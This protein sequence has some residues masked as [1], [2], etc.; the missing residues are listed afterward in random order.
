MEADADN[1]LP[2]AKRIS[3]CGLSRIKFDEGG[4]RVMRTSIEGRSMFWF[5]GDQSGCLQRIAF[6]GT[7]KRMATSTK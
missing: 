7:D 5:W 6:G 4:K 2:S 1:G 3:G